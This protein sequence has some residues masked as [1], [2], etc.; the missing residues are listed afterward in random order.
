[1][2]SSQIKTINSAVEEARNS[3]PFDYLFQSQGISYCGVVEFVLLTIVSGGPPTG[4]W[5]ET[6]DGLESRF[7]VQVLSKFAFLSGLAASGA[8]SS[9]GVTICAPGQ[10]GKTFDGT[11]PGLN[12]AHEQG[13]YG[14]LSSGARDS[15]VMDSVHLEL[16]TK[17][18]Q[19]RFY[20]LFPGFVHTKAASN[21]GFPF[22]IPQLAAL[23]GPAMAMVIGMP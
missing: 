10:G 18:P 19:L 21:S 8:L 13:K 11:D 22:P 6:A 16:A 15:V 2:L 4:R 14:F 23:F 1:M 7:A 20:H 9:A 12:K 5:S 3:G 17:Y